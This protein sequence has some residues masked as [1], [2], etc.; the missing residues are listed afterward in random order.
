MADSLNLEVVVA[1]MVARAAQAMH[2]VIAEEVFPRTQELC[3][4]DSGAL[5]A[6]GKV[7][8][9]DK[10]GLVMI[11]YGDPGDKTG[12]YAIVQHERLDL[13]HPNGGVAKYVEIPLNE[14]APTLVGRIAERMR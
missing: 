7:T 4:R 6:T 5:V 10:D 9:P 1:S 3:P 13:N 8:D 12:I 14:A 2:D 11:T